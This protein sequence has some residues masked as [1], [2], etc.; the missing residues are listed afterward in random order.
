M[1]NLTD[2]MAK[3]E[4]S[5]EFK[6]LSPAGQSVARETLKNKVKGEYQALVEGKR[7]KA[8]EQRVA[9]DETIGPKASSALHSLVAGGIGA[10]DT[11]TFG[12]LPKVVSAMP[13]TG[14]EEEIRASMDVA[15][16]SNP[17][18]TTVGNVAGMFRGPSAALSRLG[19][20]AIG[21]VAGGAAT[22]VG[23]GR[24]IGALENE[25]A[26]RFAVATLKNLAT[27]T[28]AIATNELVRSREDDAGIGRRLSDAASMATNPVNLA[29]SVAFGAVQA[30]LQRPPSAELASAV[31]RYERITGKRVPI[32]TL[33]DSAA[34][35]SFYDTIARVPGMEDLIQRQRKDAVS[36]LKAVVSDIR[37]RVGAA[38]GGR[39]VVRGQ[40][41]RAVR[42]LVGDGADSALAVERRTVAA[43]AIGPI[44]AQEIPSHM[45]GRLAR[46]WQRIQA[47]RP[48][49]TQ[50]P[51]L[52]AAFA[53]ISKLQTGKSL[54][55]LNEFEALR[56]QIGKI[57]H[58]T[59][60]GARDV[61]SREKFEA[62][63]A[64]DLI[65]AL[66]R[67]YYPQYGNALNVG[68][69]LRAME[70]ALGDVNVSQLDDAMLSSFF[71]S[72]GAVKNWDTLVAKS[73]PDDIAAAKGW[74]FHR[75]MGRVS[76]ADGFINP[77]TL[78]KVTSRGELNS[79]LI[80]KVL[81]GLLP[82]LRDHA[83]LTAGMFGKGAGRFGPVGSQ[84]A[85]RGARLVNT[86]AMGGV[87]AAGAALVHYLSNPF[88]GALAI[89][90]PV[91][92]KAAIR[93]ALGGQVENAMQTLSRNGP[94]GITRSA[95]AA[96]A[97]TPD[98]GP[99]KQ[100]IIGLPRGDSQ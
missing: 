10:A 14:S 73:T 18:A 95:V 57:G 34:Q 16:E 58:S 39:E 55:T 77:E 80:D 13:G 63:R 28:G 37:S 78:D 99:L 76:N 91:G 84:T 47:G 88:V 70:S 86:M 94:T 92:V 79:Q 4:A 11:A 56:Q 43:N 46:G 81:P 2:R 66:G 60:L 87:P 23:G 42:N 85:S 96:Q 44:G 12:Y 90:G 32:E 52:D 41:A 19:G 17:I 21:R 100:S 65:S 1:S 38:G 6:A 62:R 27:G 74:L 8:G 5:S 26:R 72:K 69:S 31:A 33:T 61:G 50:S 64:Y 30:K 93:S 24:I 75:L 7:A 97:V 51:E 49:N 20:N 68:K 67:R 45:F 22:A 98:I 48:R 53:E 82:E 35:K 83:K 36:G 40:A 59:V 15:R 25:F 3:M 54:P 71:S 89:L 9:M 29:T